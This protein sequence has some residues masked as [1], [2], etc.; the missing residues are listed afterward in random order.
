MSPAGHPTVFSQNQEQC[1]CRLLQV[2]GDWGCPLTK[3][4]I[5]VV[6][7]RM[8]SAEGRT[9]KNFKDNTPGLDWVSSFLKRHKNDLTVRQAQNSKAVRGEKTAD[10]MNR[11]FDNLEASLDGVPVL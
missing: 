9:V 11:Y 6:A 2:C 3:F 1:L 5:R 10:E 8:L 4:D 7:K